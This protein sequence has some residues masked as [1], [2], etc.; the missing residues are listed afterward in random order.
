MWPGSSTA[1]YRWGW[2]G[3]RRNGSPVL[4]ALPECQAPPWRVGQSGN[5]TDAVLICRGLSI[6]SGPH[7]SQNPDV[8]PPCDGRSTRKADFF[9]S[10]MISLWRT[11]VSCLLEDD[12]IILTFKTKVTWIS[13]SFFLPSN[14]SN[15]NLRMWVLVTWEIM[16]EVL[17]AWNF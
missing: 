9:F 1:V 15:I 5:Q 2:W 11:I 3:P 17:W 10:A 14:C 6:G 4:R 12:L 13:F 8:P 7:L 16:K